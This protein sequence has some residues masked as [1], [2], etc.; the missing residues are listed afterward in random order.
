MV[1]P[2]LSF[3]QSPLCHIPSMNVGSHRTTNLRKTKGIQRLNH[4][5]PHQIVITS[6]PVLCS[7]TNIAWNSIQNPLL[8][9]RNFPTP[10][11]SG[12]TQSKLRSLGPKPRL[13]PQGIPCIPPKLVKG[14][15]GL[16]ESTLR[17][18]L[19]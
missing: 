11:L 6:K 15:L 5:H 7:Q 14:F 18:P 3:S 16:S 2:N 8:S 1:E 12:F 19:P 4:L 9:L 13:I 17:P 10:C